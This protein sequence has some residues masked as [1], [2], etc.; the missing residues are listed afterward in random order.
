MKFRPIIWMLRLI[1][2]ICERERQEYRHAMN[3]SKA[4]AHDLTR[5]LVSLNALEIQKAINS[6]K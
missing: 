6:H 1:A 2:P 3:M 4:H 5:T